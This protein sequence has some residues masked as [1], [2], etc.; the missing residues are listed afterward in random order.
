MVKKVKYY[1]VL[2]GRQTGIF[3]RWANGAQEQVAG[4]PNAEHRSFATLELAKEWYRQ[5]NP[6][7]HSA[8]S[9]VLHFA[10]DDNPAKLPVISQL[11]LEHLAAPKRQYAVYLI[12][13]P[14][15]GH[16]FYVGQTKNP[17]RRWKEHLK[18]GLTQSRRFVA[19]QI[20]KILERGEQ[21]EFQV[22]L[23]CNTEAD[24]L[25][26]ESE[27]IRRCSQ[28]GHKVSNRTREH[29]E[30]KEL[31]WRPKR[32]SVIAEPFWLGPY[33][34]ASKEDFCEKLSSFLN[35]SVPGPVSHPLAIQ[36]L[37]LLVLLHAGSAVL[38]GTGIK[39][40]FVI[41][42]ENRRVLKLLRTDDTYSIFSYEDCLL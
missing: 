40:F 8:H 37:T 19:R 3:N 7:P 24:A 6:H 33:R 17:E 14:R 15:T 39:Q 12:L 27:W 18:S 30:L 28:E 16:P 1:V 29:L 22:V 36:K 23:R 10:S 25:S 2:R 41:E 26:A 42:A 9:A 38:I 11:P 20:Q 4:F 31:Y 34:Y 5:N 35:K 13:D 21:P 32:P